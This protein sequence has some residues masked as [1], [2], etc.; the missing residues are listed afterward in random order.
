MFKKFKLEYNKKTGKSTGQLAIGEDGYPI[1]KE[2]KKL[3]QNQAETLVTI[4][5]N[6]ST[7]LLPASQDE[8]ISIDTVKDVFKQIPKADGGPIE[9]S[10]MPRIDF[11]GGGAVGADDDF[12]K[13]KK[14]FFRSKNSTNK[15]FL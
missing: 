11:N 6:L 3:T 4:I 2:G 12:A 7:Q 14:N 10:P 9:L 8:T 13:K 1:L 15:I 5:E